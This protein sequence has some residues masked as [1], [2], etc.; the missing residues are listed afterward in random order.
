LVQ[1]PLTIV[2]L[3]DSARLAASRGDMA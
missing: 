3:R 2:T 1:V